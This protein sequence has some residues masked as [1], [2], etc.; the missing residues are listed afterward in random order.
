[1]VDFKTII[2]KQLQNRTGHLVAFVLL[3]AL[4]LVEYVR[5]VYANYSTK[6]FELSVRPA[7]VIIGLLLVAL[8]SLWLFV[9][10][11]G[12]GAHA[13]AAD[14]GYMYVLSLFVAVAFFLPSVVMYQV[15]GT[16]LWLPVYSLLFVFLLSAPFLQLPELRTPKVGCKVQRW[17]L[18]A[19]ALLMLVP[20]IV[21][22][23]A[24]IDWSVFT[25]GSNTYEVRSEANIKGN[26][27]TA[28]LLGPLVKVILPLLIV[29][30]FKQRHPVVWAPGILMMLYIFA[31]NPQKTILISVFVVVIFYCFDSYKSKAG[32]L[33]YGFLAVCALS[34]L[35]N[36]VTGNLMVESIAVRR[37]FFIPVQVADC[38]FSFFKG[39]PLL[40][41]HSFL[42]CFFDYPYA[43]E[44][45]NLIGS[46]MYG[47]EVT[48]C[49]TGVIADGYMNF[50][51]LGALLFVTIAAAVVR[52]LESLKL[53][54]AYMGLSLLLVFTFLNGAL[55]TTM[56]THG[57][58]ALLLSAMFLI[59]KQAS[60]NHA[61]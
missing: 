4:L 52:F 34:A 3:Y 49:N 46:V 61:T 17:L 6:G 36:I 13:K 22:Y 26:L 39:A 35:L 2:Y 42:G 25:M 9:W 21:A 30:G 48:H 40:L 60:V 7:T 5:F 27:L 1:M 54:P 51:H 19:M 58:W 45:A 10:S 33:I 44:P 53:D 11:R 56:L 31:V 59:P 55:F 38:Y 41:S 20:F 29:Y 50:G 43:V 47:R 57:G 18:P 8:A 23:R 24:D 28:Y 32:V 37:M 14:G 16:T 15:G 12:G